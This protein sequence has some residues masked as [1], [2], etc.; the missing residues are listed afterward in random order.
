[1]A[2]AAE[3]ER[4]LARLFDGQ[5]V[6]IHEDGRRL[7]GWEDAR[8]EVREGAKALLHLWSSDRSLV[9]RVARI[10]EAGDDHIRL[11]V[12]RFG[13]ARPGRLEIRRLDRAR[14]PARVDRE[15]FGERFAGLLRQQFPDES[16]ESFS[17]AAD[18]EHSLSGSYARGWLRRGQEAWAV[19]G[20]GHSE[21]RDAIDGSLAFGLLWLDWLRSRAVAPLVAGLRLILPAGASR[22]AAH[23]LGALAPNLAVELYEWVAD[24]PLARR[25]DPADI[26]NIETWLTPRRETESVLARV[27]EIDARIRALAP[28]SIDSAVVPGTGQVA[29]RFR[30]LEFARWTGGLIRFGLTGRQSELGE[31]DWDDLRRLVT[32]LAASRQPGAGGNDP[33]YRVAKERW[34]ESMVLADPARIEPRLDASQVYSQVPAFSASDRGVLDLLAITR[35]GRLAVIEL[36]A[37]EDLQLACQAV[38]YWLRVRWHQHEGDFERYGYFPGKT[39]DP[40]PPLLY[41]VAPALRFHPATRI[42]LRYLSPEIT[43]CRVGL[44]EGWRDGLQ[45]I[46]R[47]WRSGSSGPA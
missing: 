10:V 8:Y 40:A 30:G 24:E 19:L 38:D 32:S 22:L 14:R 15:R 41:L 11:E 6:E 42:L 33:L 16:L 21:T 37:D 47:E 36:K 35:E 20:A 27:A 5:P 34:L 18:L 26:G 17:T 28:G 43:I 1:M 12:E 29:W 25:I 31:P 45:V 9:R 13:Q 39:F 2:A 46:Q 44:N 3:L 4:L 7:P 23:R